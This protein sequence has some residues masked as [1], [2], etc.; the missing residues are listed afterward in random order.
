M[1]KPRIPTIEQIVDHNAY[2]ARMHFLY[3][4]GQ[5]TIYKL[6]M[7]SSLDPQVVAR[8]LLPTQHTGVLAWV[9]FSKPEVTCVVEG[10]CGPRYGTVSHKVGEIMVAT[11]LGSFMPYTEA[12]ETEPN[13]FLKWWLSMYAADRSRNFFK[14]YKY[15]MGELWQLS[16][17]I[18]TKT[19]LEQRPELKDMSLKR[20]ANLALK[21]YPKLR[22]WIR[23]KRP[24][25][26]PRV[27]LPKKKQPETPEEIAEELRLSRLGTERRIMT[28][29]AWHNERMKQLAVSQY[30]PRHTYQTSDAETK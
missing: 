30:V 15:P 2:E 24:K 19:L 17:T 23:P 11:S 21:D 3:S 13:S 12:L 22:P 26:K 8:E 9:G 4:G 29:P 25:K 10:I 14:D 1:D 7:V 5:E 28:R 18:G 20:L 6:G 16:E 27:V